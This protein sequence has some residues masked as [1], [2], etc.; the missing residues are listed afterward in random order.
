MLEL[1]I[2]VSYCAG[3]KARNYAS[4]TKH[5]ALYYLIISIYNH[6]V[7]NLI[8]CSG[9]IM[10]NIQVIGLTNKEYL[11]LKSLFL[12]SKASSWKEFI[13]QVVKEWTQ[14]KQ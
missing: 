10:V 2:T 5:I 1:F 6:K 11:E 12:E 4:N 7:F 8:G 9:G 14:Q 3:I 13:L